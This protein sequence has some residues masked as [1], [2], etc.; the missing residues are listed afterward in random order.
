[1][2]V[3]IP[4]GPS[5]KVVTWATIDAEDYERLIV[6]RWYLTRT[7]YA[8]QASSSGN[9]VFLHR[10]VLE[11]DKGVGEI[12]HIN[13][14]KLDCRKSNLR[15]VSHLENVRNCARADSAAA[16]RDEVRRLWDEGVL[17][18]NAIATSTGRSYFFV[19]KSLRGERREGPHPNLFWTRD[20]IIESMQLFHAEQGRVPGQSD[21]N[22]QDGMPWF[23]SVYRQFGSLI[24]AREAAGFGVGLDFRKKVAA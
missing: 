6:H 13:R 19:V 18:R 9:S 15:L 17:S 3:R 12:D 11:L 10:A 7:G 14:D 2:S 4:V 1:M 23:T 22:G 8:F 16:D 5:G 24:A 21:L 20:R